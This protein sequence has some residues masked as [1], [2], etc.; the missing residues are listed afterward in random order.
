LNKKLT[1]AERSRPYM[2][3]YVNALGGRS[4]PAL[5]AS[6]L[7]DAYV[8]LAAVLAGQ[9]Q[10]PKAV[11]LLRRVPVDLEGITDVTGRVKDLL[12]RYELLSKSGAASKRRS[13]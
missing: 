1:P 10:Y 13:C 9:E 3:N 8:N 12:A 2:L 4:A 11:D 5:F 6:T 7:L